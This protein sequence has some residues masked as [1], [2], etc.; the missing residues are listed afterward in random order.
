MS[1]ALSE[2][3]SR[4]LA[5]REPAIL[6]TVSEAQGS[7]PRE[8]GAAMLVTMGESHGTIGGG[9]LEYHAID[10]ARVMLAR[11]EDAREIDLPLGPL[12]GQCCG[13]RVRLALQRAGPVQAGALRAA[14]QAVHRRSPPLLIFG[15]GHTGLALARA[16]ALL[17]FRTTL[18]DDRLEAG[19]EVPDG[20]AL[21]RLD[22]PAEAVAAAPAGAAFVI[23][24]HSHA[25]D[26]RLADA[27]L[28]RGDAAYVGMIGSATKRARFERFFLGG[29]GAPEALVQ[30]TCP[31]GGADV[32]DK[33][34]E[35]IAALVAAELIRVFAGRCGGGWAEAWEDSA[36]ASSRFV[37][38]K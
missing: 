10:T 22:D 31:I 24:T 32:P 3:L 21:V 14:E 35:V 13:G 38:S 1:V 4:L 16:V 18:V 34:P 11:G 26:Y 9:Q 2:R 28:R 29:G 15:C 8:A 33:R 12:L 30:L 6:V 5:Q 25:L 36:A 20:V 37:T 27:A 17:P 23:L 19:Q 7:T